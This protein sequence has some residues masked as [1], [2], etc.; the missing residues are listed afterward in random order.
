M[1]RV[2][3]QTYGDG[4]EQRLCS[5]NYYGVNLHIQQIHYSNTMIQM[6]SMFYLL[7]RF[8]SII[9][10]PFAFSFFL[11]LFFPPNKLL[12]NRFV[13]QQIAK[14]V[15][16]VHQIFFSQKQLLVGTGNK[17]NETTETE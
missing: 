15:K 8:K 17:F 16:Q 9:A 2:Q 13:H 1:L 10:R 7:H 6:V 14:S 5:L 11:A 12:R 4:N 3:E